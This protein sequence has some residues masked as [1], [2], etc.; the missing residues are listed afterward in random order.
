M[1]N[2]TITTGIRR[3]GSFQP[4][5]YIQCTSTSAHYGST[6]APLMAGVP[7]D[8]AAAQQSASNYCPLKPGPYHYCHAPTTPMANIG[9]D[10]Q[11]N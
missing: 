2:C 4:V 10:Y 1:N 11:G 5:P 8:S 3:N 7:V 6:P 9:P